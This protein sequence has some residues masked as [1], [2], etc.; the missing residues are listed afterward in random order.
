MSIAPEFVGSSISES[1]T[2]G[3][4]P[5]VRAKERKV[6]KTY[7]Q[8]AK[9]ETPLRFSGC[10]VWFMECPKEAVRHTLERT[11]VTSTK[12]ETVS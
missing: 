2:V 1:N 3:G 10:H 11:S 9:R 4:E 5:Y 7:V 6:E 12:D 8:Q